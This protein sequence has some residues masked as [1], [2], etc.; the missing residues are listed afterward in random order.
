MA[1]ATGAV[2]N[3]LRVVCL[4]SV[5]WAAHTSI[6]FP[7][8]VTTRKTWANLPTLPPAHLA[9]CFS[10]LRSRYL[11][12]VLPASPAYGPGTCWQS[13]L[14]LLPTVPVPAGSPALLSGRFPPS[15]HPMLIPSCWPC[16]QDAWVDDDDPRVRPYDSVSSALDDKDVVA[17][18][19]AERDQ[20]RRFAEQRKIDARGE[21]AKARE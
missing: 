16:S 3:G 20:A 7:W 10:C 9:I 14:P 6:R 2:G 19:Q 4:P 18:E 13:Y 17:T 5:L 12:A 15:R 11:P 8:T 21:L 1:R